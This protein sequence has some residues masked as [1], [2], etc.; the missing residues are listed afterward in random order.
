MGDDG[1]SVG[2]GRVLLELRQFRPMISLYHL[3]ESI[4]RAVDLRRQPAGNPLEDILTA[5]RRDRSDDL[6]KRRGRR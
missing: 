1:H 3:D 6:F 5:A 4:D 2:F